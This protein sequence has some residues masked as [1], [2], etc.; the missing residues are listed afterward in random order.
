MEIP[1]NV[2]WNTTSEGIRRSSTMLVLS[3]HVDEQICIGD[4][5]IITV[6]DI[7]GDKVRLGIEAP[8]AIPVHRKEV[9]EAIKRNNAID[10][11]RNPADSANAGG[12]NRRKR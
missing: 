8:T 3:R 1:D 2:V 5:I 11:K 7:R 12:I 9:F 10:A 4:N 6:V